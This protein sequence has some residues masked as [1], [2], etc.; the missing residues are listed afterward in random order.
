MSK[1]TLSELRLADAREHAYDLILFADGVEEAGY[2]DLARRSR[3]VSRELL[4]IAND[5]DAERSA[6]VAIQKARDEAVG[7]LAN[8][9]GE[10]LAEEL[11]KVS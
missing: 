2:P 3:I 5:L 11:R 8:Q 1:T 7:I 9:A 4:E 10:A 6:R